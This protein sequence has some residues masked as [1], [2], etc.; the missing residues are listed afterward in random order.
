MNLKEIKNELQKLSQMVGDWSEHRTI[1]PLERDLALEKLRAVYESLRFGIDPPI[2]PAPKVLVAPSA[3]PR[4]E[5]AAAP[6]F[7]RPESVVEEDAEFEMVDLSEV[8]SLDEVPESEPAP[9]APARQTAPSAARAEV[10]E[11]APVASEEEDDAFD[12]PEIIEF[13]PDP[14]PEPA[15]VHRAPEPRA[16][17]VAEPAPA[18]PAAPAPQLSGVQAGAPRAASAPAPAAPRPRPFPQPEQPAP[19][20]R[21]AAAAV[22][23]TPA[24]AP[25][26]P[27]A[28][29]AA[30]QPAPAPAAKQP[31]EAPAETQP[32]E[33]PSL[34]GPDEAVVRH[35]HKQRV[36]MSL[37]DTVPETPNRRP[38]EPVAAP[39]PAPAPEP[40]VEPVPE[41]RM[42]E[43]EASESEILLLDASGEE[44]AAVQP[45]SAA[46]AE[47]RSSE[48]AG[49]VLG[50]VINHDV[51]T[52]GD[53]IVRPRRSVGAPVSDLRHAIGI[54][55]KFLMIR[56]LFG[57]D[58]ALFDAT[59]A[60]LNAQESLD[61]CMIYIA[62]NFA[63]NPESESAKLVMELLER[64][65]A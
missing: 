19:A 57:G 17:F 7:R 58:G 33:V 34:F 51:Q 2:E 55:D 28:R 56:D 40:V 65:F 26:Q 39:R 41:P 44:P 36:I 50:E 52:L 13:E 15:P 6:L 16:E 64:K 11:P 62:E 23:Q 35:R 20:A 30:G 1:A 22:G 61:D 43:P 32:G 18:A 45:Q 31:A 47:P 54:N 3:A 53:T 29:P 8:L 14:E 59:I 46:G 63:W 42:P 10:R 21:P 27:V 5:S 12:G 24:Q 37:Y 38:A 25:V 49:Q 48:Q 60:A 9:A 4:P